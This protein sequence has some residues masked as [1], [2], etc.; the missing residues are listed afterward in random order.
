[1]K[2]IIMLLLFFAIA[3][4]VG[5][6]CSITGEACAAPLNFEANTLQDKLVP[7]NL[8]NLQRTDSFQPQIVTPYGSN[9]HTAPPPVTQSPEASDYDANCQFGNCLPENNEQR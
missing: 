3:M 1:M 8:Q 9:V 2:K 5:A 6:V 4:P 7:N